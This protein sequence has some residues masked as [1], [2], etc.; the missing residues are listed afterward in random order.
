MLSSIWIR[1]IF[2]KDLDPVN[3]RTD[4]KPSSHLKNSNTAQFLCARPLHVICMKCFAQKNVFFLYTF[5]TNILLTTA[6]MT[7]MH[8]H[9][10]VKG[11]F[12]TGGG[13]GSLKSKTGKRKKNRLRLCSYS[14]YRLIVF[15]SGYL[16]YMNYLIIR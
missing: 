6:G 15:Q 12:F 4:P 11:I 10:V 2:L 7:F 14:Y 9:R 13:I 3:L 1:G 5:M 8:V 16:G